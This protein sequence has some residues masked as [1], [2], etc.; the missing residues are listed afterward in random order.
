MIED[1]Y[2]AAGTRDGHRGECKVC[3]SAAKKAWYEANRDAVT[4]KVKRWQQENADWHNAQ[5]RVRR[6]DPVRKRKERDGHLRRKYGITV[7]QYEEMLARQGAVCGICLR[8]PNPNI[9]LHV[10]HDHGPGRIRGL[11]C[12]RCNQAMGAFGEDP[13]LLRAAAAYLDEHDPEVA[14]QREQILERVR[15]IPPPIWKRSA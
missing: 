13:A 10:D 4:A 7:D 14:S 5:Q 12:F 2:R 3:N 15:Q 1:F 6:Q 8:E 11:T 9:S